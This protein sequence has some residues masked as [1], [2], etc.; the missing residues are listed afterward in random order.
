MQ[1]KITESLGPIVTH[2]NG[3]I[4]ITGEIRKEIVM[5]P[6]ERFLNELVFEINKWKESDFTQMQCEIPEYLGFTLKELQEFLKPLK[7]YV[8]QSNGEFI[9]R[10]D[11]EKEKSWVPVF[12]VTVIVNKRIIPSAEKIQFNE[13]E[14][15][16]WKY[17]DYSDIRKKI[18]FE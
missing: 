18:L 12:D 9:I 6:K 7:T 16:E 17:F 1:I 2:P 13:Q 8:L 10:G 11:R 5:N 4:S 3:D 14:L 15:N